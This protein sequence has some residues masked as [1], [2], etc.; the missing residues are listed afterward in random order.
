MITSFRIGE[1]Q[2]ETLP[3]ADYLLVLF[4]SF[5]SYLQQL[6][7]AFMISICNL[8]ILLEISLIF[9]QQQVYHLIKLLTKDFA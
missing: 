7:I 1:S 9:K 4:E 6:A 5:C 2:F 8:V 3:A